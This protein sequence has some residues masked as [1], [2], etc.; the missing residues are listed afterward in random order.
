MT[1]KIYISFSDDWFKRD[2]IRL[3]IR[4]SFIFSLYLLLFYVFQYIFLSSM[5][6]LYLLIWNM[7]NTINNKYIS[8]YNDF[9]KGVSD[10]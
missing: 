6:I 4:L 5:E 8:I 7:S 2:T 9:L 1:E 3:A 10:P